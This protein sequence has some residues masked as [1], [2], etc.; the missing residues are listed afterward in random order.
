LETGGVPQ[1]YFLSAKACAGILRRAAKR[2]KKVPEILAAA[3]ASS[4]QR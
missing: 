3:L 1:R 2:G 4:C